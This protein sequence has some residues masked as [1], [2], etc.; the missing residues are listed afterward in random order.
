MVYQ[1]ALEAQESLIQLYR[2]FANMKGTEYA[3]TYFTDT[4]QLSK[5]C[6]AEMQPQV[7]AV[8]FSLLW[9]L[10]QPTTPHPCIH[11]N[12]ASAS[13]LNWKGFQDIDAPPLTI[14]FG[15]DITRQSNA[16]GSPRPKPLALTA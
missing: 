2:R 8:P 12:C 9:R 7:L 13:G 16:C 4:N 1:E 11:G 15:R 14:L 6:E 3:L 5:V 10:E